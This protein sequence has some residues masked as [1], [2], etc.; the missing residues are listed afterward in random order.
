M[1]PIILWDIDGT[2]VR[3]RGQRVTMTA[4]IQALQLASQIGELQYPGDSHGKTDT[5]IA[6]EMLAAASLDET[7]ARALLAGFGDGYL[8]AL[9]QQRERVTEDLEVLP[10]VPQLLSALKQ[11]N[12]TQSLL[13]GNLEPIARLKLAC[14]GLDSYVDFEIG[15]FGSDHHDRSS[16]VPFVR[17]RIR[18]NGGGDTDGREIVVVG[19]TPRDIACARAG[20]ARAIAVA[21]GNFS[22]AELEAHAPDAV[23][24]DVADTHAV[25]E[26]L[27]RYSTYSDPESDRALIV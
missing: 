1:T 6:L 13:T 10:G 3:G 8:A 20:G 9:Q 15:A 19:D 18:K 24:D 2:L 4:F 26:L 23:L 11:R 21:T 22:R 25:I 27:L 16:L 14:A 12:V 17:D 7:Q 5:G